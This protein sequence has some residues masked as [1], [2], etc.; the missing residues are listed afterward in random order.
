[1][2]WMP[3]KPRF[4]RLVDAGARE[5]MRQVCGGESEWPLVLVGSA[6]AGKT[7][8]GLLLSDYVGHLFYTAPDW[9]ARVNDARFDRL[10]VSNAVCVTRIRESEVWKE[11]QDAPLV[12]LD[13]LGLRENVTSARYETIEKAIDLRENKPAVYI[14]N[15]S[16]EALGRVYDDRISSRL[17]AGTVITMDGDRRVV[18]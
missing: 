12:V 15:L 13:E 16:L 18:R 3:H 7:C 10:E 5:T 14:S 11:W 1:M 8:I 2:K 9:C 4:K 6:G 17:S